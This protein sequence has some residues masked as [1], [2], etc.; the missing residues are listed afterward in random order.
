MNRRLVSVLIFALV[1]ASATSYLLYRLILSRVQSSGRAVATNMLVVAKHDLQVGTLIH[2][3]DIEEVAWPGAVPEEAAKTLADALN[4]G[5]V[6]NIYR[7][8]PIFNGRLASRGAGAGLA[9]TIPVGMRAEAIRVNEVV[10]LAGFVL[11]GMRV[12]VLMAEASADR[13]VWSPSSADGD[14][15]IQNCENGWA[16]TDCS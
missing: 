4:R 1:V 9:A 14:T 10:G 5:V 7:G 6:A 12:D 8:E 16:K 15:C 3:V 13:D 11:P 2:D